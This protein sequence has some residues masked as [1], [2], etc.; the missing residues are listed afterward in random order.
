[1]EDAVARGRV[2]SGGSGG[3]HGVDRLGWRRWGHEGGQ[4]RV[5]RAGGTV[6]GDRS[7][8]RD[9]QGRASGVGSVG[10]AERARM[11]G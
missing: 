10:R 7:G 5:E 8:R 11:Q 4:R 1:M 2:G 3:R 6:T 9:M